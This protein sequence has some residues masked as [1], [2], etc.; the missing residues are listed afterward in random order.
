MYRAVSL[1]QRRISGQS[2]VSGVFRATWAKLHG[3]HVMTSAGGGVN[4]SPKGE[5]AWI[6]GV[7]VLAFVFFAGGVDAGLA[8]LSHQQRIKAGLPQYVEFSQL[9]LHTWI[10]SVD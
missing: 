10:L 9:Y 2:R 1:G 5:I 8:A 7:A 6:V 3:G 4:N